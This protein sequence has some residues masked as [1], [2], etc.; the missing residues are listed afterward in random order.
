[1]CQLM[2]E[3]CACGMLVVNG[4]PHYP[5]LSVH[6]PAAHHTSI[7]TCSRVIRLFNNSQHERT[8]RQTDGST[9]IPNKTLHLT[10]YIARW[11]ALH[12]YGFMH[13]HSENVRLI[14]NSFRWH[15]DCSMRC[16]CCF[17][18][19]RCADATGLLRNWCDNASGYN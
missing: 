14:R 2:M 13:S 12:F 17:G 10:W 9:E 18:N 19:H 5:R 15:V 3:L 4:M 8:N 11:C 7:H 16:C 6:P 1:M